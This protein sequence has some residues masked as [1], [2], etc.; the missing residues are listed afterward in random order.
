MAGWAV[1]SPELTSK[2]PLSVESY[3][4]LYRLTTLTGC[5]RG[6]INN[7]RWDCGDMISQFTLRNQIYDL[8]QVMGVEEGRLREIIALRQA[9]RILPFPAPLVK[10]LNKKDGA[11]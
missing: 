8:S 9:V 6:E 3:S 7:P 1:V 10:K 2:A 11:I 5:G 4:T